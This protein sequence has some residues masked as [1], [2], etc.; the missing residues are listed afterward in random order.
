MDYSCSIFIYLFVLGDK[1]IF[2]R[3]KSIRLGT[4]QVA[5][6]EETV[7]SSHELFAV[8]EEVKEKVLNDCHR[9]GMTLLDTIQTTPFEQV[10]IPEISNIYTSSEN[11]IEENEENCHLLVDNSETNS[12]KDPNLEDRDDIER[13]KC[14]FEEFGDSEINI[15]DFSDKKQ[16]TDRSMINIRANG[17]DM[18]VKKSTLCWF[19]SNKLG[20]LSSDR[21]LRVRGMAS[22]SGAVNKRKKGNVTKRRA[23]RSK[24]NK[25]E[26]K[27]STVMI[28]ESETS[29]ETEPDNDSYSEKSEF[30]NESFDEDDSENGAFKATTESKIDFLVEKY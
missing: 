21:L 7:P 16:T 5:N 13:E 24:I 30:E 8:I 2:P 20:R 14:I 25:N 23:K 1:F 12:V 15:K 26:I 27:T 11:N 29:S 17:K 18:I 9:L 3:E 28:S 6:G 4:R 22:T 10:N 19:F